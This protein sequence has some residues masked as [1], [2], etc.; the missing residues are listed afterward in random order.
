MGSPPLVGASMCTLTSTLLSS[1]VT[2][3]VFPSGEAADL[4]TPGTVSRVLV[5]AL[6][7]DGRGSRAGVEVS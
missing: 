5:T 2:T 7:R 6:L 4:V 1:S 3:A